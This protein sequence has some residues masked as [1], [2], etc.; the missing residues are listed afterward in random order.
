MDVLE[1][2]DAKYDVL[3]G[4]AARSSASVE[5]LHSRL[6]PYVA[7]LDCP[8]QNRWNLVAVRLNGTPFREGKRAGKS[9]LEILGIDSEEHWSEALVERMCHQYPATA[10]YLLTHGSLPAGQLNTRAHW[11]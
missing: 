3:L 7:A 10:D 11:Q 6:T 8:G 9:P 2:V 5:H 4:A 1:Q